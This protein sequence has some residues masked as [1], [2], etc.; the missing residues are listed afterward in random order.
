MYSPLI[1]GF[2]GERPALCSSITCWINKLGMETGPGFLD[3]E[4][5]GMY[6]TEQHHGG[7]AIQNSQNRFIVVSV[8]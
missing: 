8:T 1:R 5:P 3:L 2:P 6:S 7:W 4:I